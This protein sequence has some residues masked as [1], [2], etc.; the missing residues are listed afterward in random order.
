ME[1]QA[2]QRSGLRH[3][4]DQLARALGDET[5]REIYLWTRERSDV[6]TAEV[7]QRFGLHPNVARHHLDRLVEAGYLAVAETTQHVHV[8]RPSK[9]Y[10]APAGATLL[11]GLDGQSELL[12]ALVRRLLEEIP[13]E[14]AEAI[15]Y[16]VG[17]LHGLRLA[18]QRGSDAPSERVRVVA[19][20]LRRSGFV[21]EPTRD[22]VLRQEHCPFGKLATEHPVVCATERGLLD[23]LMESFGSVALSA[24]PVRRRP[25]CCEVRLSLPRR[26]AGRR[27]ETTS[28]T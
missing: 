14:R 6:T 25:G 13:T 28:A 1:T 4:L 27:P 24:R 23:G 9:R 2:S 18:A 20:A 15:A 21:P 22:G 17:H 19:E 8:G 26:R 3:A 10:R 5:R 12:A 7:A 16:E 11:D